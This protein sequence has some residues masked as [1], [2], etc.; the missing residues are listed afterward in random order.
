M[1]ITPKT[2][3]MTLLVSY[4]L[5][6]IWMIV[7]KQE[8]LPPTARQGATTPTPATSPS[9]QSVR[10]ETKE[11]SAGNVTVI[12]TPMELTMGKPPVFELTFETHSVDLS[13]D[14]SSVTTLT[15]DK[16]TLYGTPVWNGSPPG[17][18][19]REGALSFPKPMA[20]TSIVTLT[21]KD[22]AGVKERTFVWKL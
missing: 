19:H 11:Q 18:H 17:G 3:T 12:A 10:Y 8:T 21:L 6:A 5:V 15:D 1:T 14:V 9:N 13:F 2:I 20:Q 4:L 22:I 16:G 7:N